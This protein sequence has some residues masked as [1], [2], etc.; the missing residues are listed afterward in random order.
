MT[1]QQSNLWALTELLVCLHFFSLSAAAQEASAKPE[2]HDLHGIGKA[3]T[4]C[5]QPLEVPDHD[6]GI[7]IT[8][9]LGFDARGQ[10]LGPPQFTYFTP[11]TPERIKTEYKTLILDALKRCTPLSFSHKLGATIAGV[12]LTLSFNERGLTR[13]RLAGSSAYVAPVPLPSSRIPPARPIPPLLQPP[14]RRESPIWLPGLASP[15]PSLPHGTETSQDRQARCIFQSRL[16]GVPP[17][18]LSQ[19]M[20]LC[21]Q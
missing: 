12:P 15:I 3:L 5:M 17:T 2:V 6:H 21:S 20:G 13:A 10:P 7:Q 14:T 19:Y 11:K 9:R 18:D 4:D 1:T 8:A 16:Y